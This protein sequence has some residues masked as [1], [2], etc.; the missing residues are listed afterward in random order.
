MNSKLLTFDEARERLGLLPFDEYAELQIQDV[1]NPLKA[2]EKILYG[3]IRDLLRNTGRTT[4]MLLEAVVQSQYSHVKISGY[5]LS[6]SEQLT[7]DAKT[8]AKKLGL[9][10]DFILRPNDVEWIRPVVFTDHYQRCQ[11][12]STPSP[13]QPGL[14][15]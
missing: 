2:A 13:T 12:K 10:P 15:S 3:D 14:H 7:V 9:N 6:Y 1:S 8:M 11:S 5:S 4:K